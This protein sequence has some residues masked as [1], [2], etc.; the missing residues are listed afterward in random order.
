MGAPPLAG[1]THRLEV[2]DPR[3][4]MKTIQRPSGERAGIM[5][6]IESDPKMRVNLG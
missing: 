5:I 4:R 6:C 3:C 1:T 2:S